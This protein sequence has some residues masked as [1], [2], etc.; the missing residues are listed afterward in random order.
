MTPEQFAA[1]DA[2][3]PKVWRLFERF[4]FERMSCG[5]ERYSADAI[6]HRIRWETDAAHG[7]APK[8][9]NDAAAFYARKFRERHPDRAAFFRTRTSK[10]DVETAAATL[11]T[12]IDEGR[13]TL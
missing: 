8:I 13:A 3:H 7:S 1:L 5:F 4:A 11:R 2:A 12:A 9:N 6:L 10:A